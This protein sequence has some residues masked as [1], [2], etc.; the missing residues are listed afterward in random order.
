[1]VVGG[2][3]APGRGT[4]DSELGNTL[5][6]DPAD[7]V[8][9]EATRGAAAAARRAVIISCAA[10]LADEGDFSVVLGEQVTEVNV[11][12]VLSRGTSTPDEPGAIGAEGEDPTEALPENGDGAD[13]PL[14]CCD[15]NTCIAFEMACSAGGLGYGERF[16]D[17]PSL[18]KFRQQMSIIL[19]VS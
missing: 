16:S 19:Q 8:R 9:G 10:S 15:C 17:L 12:V 1:M 5:G 4:D 18:A 7:V 2:E 11:G 14:A 3:V 6:K 13:P